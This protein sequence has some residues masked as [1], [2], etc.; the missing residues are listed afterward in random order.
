M[1]P[2][3]Q[4]VCL[5]RI[6]QFLGLLNI[7]NKPCTS[8]FLQRFWIFLGLNAIAAVKKRQIF[9]IFSFS[10]LGYP[11]SKIMPWWRNFVDRVPLK[12]DVQGLS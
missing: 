8:F 6:L 1:N 10:K 3:R 11:V 5:S 12:N 9:Q 4:I 7:H 2:V